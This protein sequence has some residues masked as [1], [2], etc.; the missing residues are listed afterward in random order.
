MASF[1]GG[2]QQS[3]P[4]QEKFPDLLELKQLAKDHLVYLL[5][6]IPEQKDLVIDPG[7]MRPLDRIA[8]AQLLKSHGV[9]KIFKLDAPKL[10]VGG[11]VRMFLIRPTVDNAKF[12]A[13]QI[14]WDKKMGRNRR[15]KILFVPR[16]LYV[17]EMIL[18]EE[19][20]FGDVTCD[21]FKLDLIPLDRDILSL[22]L[23]DFFPGFFLEGDQTWLHT[24]A[25]SIVN[26]QSLFGTI[27]HVYYQGRCSQMVWELANR[28]ESLQD[29]PR[30]A[31]QKEIGHI[32]LMDRDVDYVS[33]LCTQTTYE[34]LVDETFGIRSGYCEFTPEVT[35]TGKSLRLLLDYNDMIFEEIRSRHISNVFGYL[36][37][38]AKFVQSGYEKGRS[39]G[40]SGDIRDMKQFVRNELKDLKQQF[41]SLS[42]HIGACESIMNSKSKQ[43]SFEE[44][45]QTEHSILEGVGTKDS[46]TFIEEE[47]DQQKSATTTL[48]LMCLLSLTQNGLP[49]KDFRNLQ[50]HYLHS[51]GHEQM[52]TFM[53]LRKLGL[54]TEQV[55]AEVSKMSVKDVKTKLADKV[56]KTAFKGLCKKFNL[57]PKAGEVNL[58]NPDDMSFVYSGAYVPLSCKL[59][60]QVLARGGWAG[61]DDVS[62]QLPGTSYAEHKVLS[63]RGT[64]G[65]GVVP[66]MPCDKIVL[67]YFLGGITFAEIAALKLLGKMKGYQ[68]IFA[69][70]SI[71]NGDELIKSVMDNTTY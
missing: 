47:I 8:G 45:L 55:T 58:K 70:T 48:R 23:P 18:E 43:L 17:C 22:E 39:L 5:Q 56:K 7:L 33:A 25:S 42:I 35:G 51:H 9:D 29:H 59:I 68:F 52:L 30:D 37:T 13:G 41:K 26:L 62:K 57:I 61:L 44:H 10:E 54:Y 12:I 63:A 3:F 15:Y 69:T 65:N 24:V 67:V 1:S 27:P 32:F 28:L 53:N 36:S 40:T 34:G 49:T 2:K 21:E 4:N 31:N 64:A 19:G 20:V 14:N 38:Q 66:E 11:D 16:K 6:S 46:I 50:T 71:I 60:E